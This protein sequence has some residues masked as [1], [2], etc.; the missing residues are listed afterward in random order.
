MSRIITETVKNIG[1]HA[2]AFSNSRLN[3]QQA[4][5]WAAIAMAQGLIS[6]P[7]II[8]LVEDIE[9]EEM[10]RDRLANAAVSFADTLIEEMKKRWNYEKES[11]E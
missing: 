4:R 1:A 5:V 8:G 9:E 11:G 7:N 6:N 2:E 3:W 10:D